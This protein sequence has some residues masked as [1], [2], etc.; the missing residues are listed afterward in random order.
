MGGCCL[1][2]LLLLISPR[3]F[4]LG[5]WLLSNWYNAFE[6]LDSVSDGESKFVF[7]VIDTGIGMSAEQMGRLF[8]PF[9]QVHSSANGPSPLV[10]EGT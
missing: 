7:D 6:R 9:S 4:L 8:R 1:V 3:L 2:V 5:V 10:G